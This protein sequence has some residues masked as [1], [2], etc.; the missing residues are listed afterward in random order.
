MVS[1]GKGLANKWMNPSRIRTHPVNSQCPHSSVI[2][3]KPEAMTSG[4]TNFM[5]GIT[6]IFLN[7][8]MNS[9][10]KK[11]IIDVIT[12]INS[13]FKFKCSPYLFS[14]PNPPIAHKVLQ[15]LQQDLTIAD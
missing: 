2:T 9:S 4:N 13:N 15:A 14:L 10:E 5:P 11:A 3:I 1:K 8:R 6:N 7:S 12:T